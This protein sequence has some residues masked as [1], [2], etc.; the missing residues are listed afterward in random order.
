MEDKNDRSGR[1]N[2]TKQKYRQYKFQYAEEE[3]EENITRYLRRTT[4]L[5]EAHEIIPVSV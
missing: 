1:K 3:E 5:F 4:L 2:V